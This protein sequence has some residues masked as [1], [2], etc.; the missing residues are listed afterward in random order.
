MK[1]GQNVSLGGW[2]LVA[3]N[4][5][6]AF[7]SIWIFM[8]MAPAIEGIVDQNGGSLKACEE[9]L[10]NL[11]LSGLPGAETRKLKKAFSRELESAR[12]NITKNRELTAIAAI[13][14]YYAQAFEGDA[15]AKTQTI[16]SINRL[17]R[18]NREAMDAANRN[19]RQFGYAGAWGIVFMASAV[20]LVG[21]LFMRNLKNSL[22][23]PLEEIYTVIQA[24]KSG[25]IMRRCTG[26]DMPRDVKTI[27]RGI[28]DMLDRKNI[29]FKT[30][31]KNL[32]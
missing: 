2:M 5:V 17:I 3:L 4:L 15:A 13:G 23:A 26:P 9:M 14:R 25:D 8:R 31:E 22:V 7:G 1:L 11:A 29:D 6:M 32:K 16:A 12:N 27:F 10:S 28:N 30:Q 18:M 20:F 19:A 24:V 21:M